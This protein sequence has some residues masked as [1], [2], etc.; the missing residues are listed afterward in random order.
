METMERRIYCDSPCV[1]DWQAEVTGVMERGGKFH[2]SL[3]KEQGLIT[4]KS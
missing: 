4:A 1:T 3:S 2:V